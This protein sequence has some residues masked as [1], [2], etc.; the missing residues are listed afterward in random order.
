MPTAGGRHRRWPGPG[1]EIAGLIGAP[2][3]SL[4]FTGCATEA[5][6]LALRGV[7]RALRGRG[8]HLII[9]AVEHPSVIGPA[10]RLRADGWAVTVLPVDEYGQVDPQALEAALRP[11]TVLVSVMLA[12]NE[13]GTLQ[14]VAELA[15]M[16]RPRGILLHTDAAQAVG[17]IPVKVDELGVDLLTLA[18][19]KFYAP[20]GVGAL[21]VRPGT[22]IEP[23][24]VGGGQEQGLRP[25]TEN[26]P[27][28]VALGAAARLAAA[29]LTAEAQRLRGLRDRL[30]A[31]LQAVI[32]GL[33]LNGH[34]D[35]RLSNTLNLSFPEV[36]GRALL[37][38]VADSIA[39]SVGS[40][41]HADSDAVSGVL[42]AMGC[43]AEQAR[44]AVRLSVG[45]FTADGDIDR[46]AEVLLNAHAG[47]SARD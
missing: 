17:K 3:G 7:A 44:G 35:Q 34:P 38:A 6:N 42:A 11:D 46:A 27:H 43:T 14:P 22:P 25:G 26:V 18:G 2:P 23:L 29:G 37:D 30:H 8:R 1:E 28:I 41:C 32:P 20:K 15:E 9:S 19:H 16:T 45:R 4:Y 40:A 47:L 10:E 36:T 33:R 12:N 5:N 39:A 21:Y 31:R 24:L 13:V